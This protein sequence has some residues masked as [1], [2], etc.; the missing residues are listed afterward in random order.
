VIVT[1]RDRGGWRPP[2]G[3]DRGRGIPLMKALMETV[4]VRQDEEGTT[5]VLT[6]RLE[7]ATA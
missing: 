7:A 4:E 2:R 6:R 3:R 5:V 1:V